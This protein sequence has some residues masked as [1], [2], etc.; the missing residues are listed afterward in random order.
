M[1]DVGGTGEGFE[2]G[3]GSGGRRPPNRAA[4]SSAGCPIPP[5]GTPLCPVAPHSTSSRPIHPAGSAARHGE[6]RPEG[7][8]PRQPGKETG[9]SRP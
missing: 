8:A 4:T 6:E 2:V 9:W 5:H 7:R 1:V 3:M